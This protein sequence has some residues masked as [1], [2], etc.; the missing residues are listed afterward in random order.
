MKKALLL[1]VVFFA[2][3]SCGTK[4]NDDV[5]K[6]AFQKYAESNFDDP[7]KV[8]EVVAVA[9]GDT[10]TN[11]SFADIVSD[12][13]AMSDSLVN[14]HQNMTDKANTL[15]NQHVNKIRY[16]QSFWNDWN[17]FKESLDKYCEK[18]WEFVSAMLSGNFKVID[19]DSIMRY[20]DFALLSFTLKY[21]IMENDGLKLKDIHGRID[22]KTSD[23]YIG[24]SINSDL[25]L[26]LGN[27]NKTANYYKCEIETGSDVV[28]KAAKVISYFE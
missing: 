16:N 19:K 1:I 10:V 3:I 5:I 7:S 11:K 20:A 21:R 18:K 9:Y 15:A 17:E 24:E 22:L 23:V 28:Q 8:K 6:E 14:L 26:F 4:T 13:S 12:L 27:I 25:L 2:L